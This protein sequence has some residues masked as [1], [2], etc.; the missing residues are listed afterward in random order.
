[1]VAVRRDME[2]IRPIGIVCPMAEEFADLAA[3]MGAS[4]A[5]QRGGFA[6]RVGRLEGRPVVLAEGGIGKVAAASVATLLLD[7]FGCRALLIS[8]VAGGLDPS[9]GIGDVVVAERLVQ[10]DYGAL[11]AGE[12]KHFRPG[13]P[14]LGEPREALGYDLDGDVKAALARVLAGYRLPRLPESVASRSPNLRFGTVITG[15]QFVNCEATRLRLYARF[16]AQAAD[17]ESAA[18]AQVAERYGVPWVVVRCLSDLAGADSHLDFQ[19][20]LAAAALTA[21]GVVRRIVPVL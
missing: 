16:A 18:L 6:L 2:S 10:H 7:G 17:M 9:L 8:G 19:A 20:F 1:M 14:P 4:E 15:D 3:G 12:F 13:V 5:V 11:V 21:A